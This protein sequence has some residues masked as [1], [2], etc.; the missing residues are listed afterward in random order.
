MTDQER[1]R[2]IEAAE[3]LKRQ[4]TLETHYRA[5][6]S[7]AGKEWAPGRFRRSRYFIV[8]VPKN[9]GGLTDKFEQ[10]RNYVDN[11]ERFPLLYELVVGG[12]QQ[13]FVVSRILHGDE[14]DCVEIT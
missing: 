13:P 9:W 5:V 2:L 11:S 3:E 1:D 10:T 4:R 14:G 8:S 6:L 12:S 7:F